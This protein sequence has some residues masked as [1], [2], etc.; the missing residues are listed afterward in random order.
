MSVNEESYNSI[1]NKLLIPICNIMR[2]NIAAINME[3]LMD[4]LDENLS[5]DYVCVSNVRQS[6]NPLGTFYRG[7]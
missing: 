4:Y 1:V 2:V 5:G 6:E 7:E 3:W